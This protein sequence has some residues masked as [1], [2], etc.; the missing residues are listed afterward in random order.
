MASERFP[1]DPYRPGLGADDLNPPMGMDPVMREDARLQPDAELEEGPAST[2]R[3]AAFAIAIA[4]ILG[5][6]FYGLNNTS[7]HEASTTPPAQT[8]QTNSAAPANNTAP[9]TTTGVATSSNNNAATANDNAK[10]GSS[11]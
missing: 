2:G 10:T 4:V 3:I 6:V 8:A 5:A 7:V 9:G 1:N 11:K